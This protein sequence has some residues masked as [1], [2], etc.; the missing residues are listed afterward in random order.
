DD[1]APGVRGIGH[2]DP[3]RLD[4]APAAV[5]PVDPVLLEKL[6]DA[7]CEAR[8]N[9]VLAAHHSFQIQLDTTYLDAVVRCLL[10][11][12]VEEFARIQER[13]GGDA[14][15]VQAGAAE[16]RAAL[17]AGGLEAQ[18]CGTDRG[19]IAARSA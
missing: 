11:D 5:D 16:C 17:D 14:A 3:V 9:P 18:L 4:Q 8:D 19:D 6:L 12:L 1:R 13:L 2:F 15:D 7:P 10:L